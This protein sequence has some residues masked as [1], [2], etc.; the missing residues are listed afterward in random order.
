MIIPAQFRLVLLL[1]LA[2]L[3]RQANALDWAGHVTI[4]PQDGAIEATDDVWINV[5]SAPSGGATGARVVYSLDDGSNWSAAEMNANGQLGRHDWWHVNLG[6]FA[7]GTTIR[8]AVEVFAG[9]GGSLWDSNGGADY[10][11]TVNGGAGARWFGHARHDPPNQQVDPGETVTVSFETYPIGTAVSAR[12]VSSTDGFNWTSVNLAKTGT[13][14]ANDLWQG[15]IGSF[16]AATTNFYAI[17]VT[18]GP[19]DK[20]WDTNNGANYPVIVNSPYPGQWVGNT[21]HSPVNGAI[22]PGE[23]LSILAES[24]PQAK[25]LS[26]KAAYSVNGG[27]WQEANLPWHETSGSNDVW[28]GSLG[29]FAAGDRIQYATAVNFGY[30]GETWD[31]AGGTNYL[32]IV[33]SGTSTRWVGNTQTYPA[34]GEIDPED[35]LWINTESRL[36]SDSVS[37]RVVWRAN[38]GAWTSTPM[39]PNGTSGNKALWHVNLG[40]FPAGTAIEFAVEVLFADAETLWDNAGGTNH[41]AVVNAPLELLAVRN[42]DYWPAYGSIEAGEEVWINTETEPAGAATTVRVIYTTDDTT[43]LA[44]NLAANGEENGRTRWHASLGGFGSGTTV[45]FAIEAQDSYGTSV[46][47]NNWGEDFY[48]RVNSPIR[49]LYPDKARYNP[50]DPAVISAELFNPSGAALHGTLRLRISHLF[51][52]LAVLDS[53]VTVNAGQGLTVAV[54][55]T[56]RHDDFRGYAVAAEFIA[57]GTTLDRRSTAID[58]STDWTKFPR[59]GFFSDYYEGEQSWDSAAKAKELGKYHINAVQF[60]DWMWEHDRLVPYAC[61]GRV[62]NVFTQID[63]RVQ[64]LA[65]VSNKIAAAKGLNMFTLAYDLLYGDSGTGS[66]PLHPA[67]AAYNKPWSTEPID[68]RQHPLHDHTIWVMDCSHSDWQRWIYNQY[69]DAILKLGF[70]GIHLDNLGGAWS[71]R[72]NSND[73]IWEGAAF[74][75]FIAGCRAAVRNASP[76]GRV[77]H[78]DVYAG[79]LDQIAPSD[80]D[81]YYAEVWG[82]DRY[83]D[84]RDLVLRAKERGNKQVVLAAY[85]NL[86]DYTNYLSEA[87]V[88]L[89]DACVF[90][91]GA[92]HIEL[93]EGVEMLSNHYF[94]MHW[95]PMRPTLKRAMRDYYDFIVKYENLLFF[96]TLGGVSDG[97]AGA[98]LASASHALSKNGQSGAIWTTVRLWHDEFDTLNLINLNGVDELWR[99]RSGRPPAQTNIAL[100]YHADKK[101]QQVY[102]ATPDDGLGQPQAL[103][104]TEGSDS[105]GYFIEFTVPRLEYWDL[106]VL[107]KRTEIKIDGW[108]GDWTGAAPADIHATTIDRGEWVYKGDTNDYRTFSGAST[109][110]DLTEVRLTCDDT[111]VYFL[112]RMQ[113]IVDASRPAIGIA[114]NAHAGSSSFPWLGD[115]STPSGSIGLENASQ[116]AT[117]EIMVYSAGGTP[118]I[119]LFNG[120]IW[121]EPNAHDSAVAVSADNDCLEFRINRNDLDLFCPQIATISLATFRSS[122]NEAGNDATYDSPDGNNDGID[123]L[124]GEIGVA[125]NSWGRDLA[126]DRIGRSYSILFSPQGAEADLRVAWPIFDGQRIDIL[127]HEAYTVVARFTET[128]PAETSNFVFAVNGV[129][130]NPSGYFFQDETPG[131]FMN[132]IRFAWT[133]PD[134]GVCTVAVAYAASG[135]ALSAARIVNL[136]PDTDGDGIPDA[137]ED[138]NRNDLYEPLYFGE[139]CHTNTDTDGDGLPDGF[140]DGNRDGRITGDLNNNYRH[141]A[142]EQW[143]ETDPRQ[144]DTDGD[145]LPDGWEVAQNLNPWDDGIIGHTN[146]NTGAP[147]AAPD[148]GAAGDPDSDGA[149]NHEEWI[150]GTDPRSSVSVFTFSDIAFPAG[151]ETCVVAWRSISGRVYQIYTSTNLARAF[152]PVGLCIT[153][154]ENEVTT[155]YPPVGGPVHARFYQ[156]GVTAP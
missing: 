125:E 88:R 30:G 147:I 120:D 75:A 2:L 42:S 76:D 50:G 85:M 18:F 12:V 62:M 6:P 47:D 96:N 122:G 87:S 69:Q 129:V 34:Q 44:A 3:A 123:L 5:E 17:E 130:Q 118:R 32:A 127:S 58:V 138:V 97:T 95:P 14:G 80:V 64:S 142:G 81:V 61:D 135:Y 25:G 77:L 33:N 84:V 107:D 89:M 13:I 54:P 78:N 109:D 102:V 16:P 113:D 37:A 100:K 20:E 131:D 140:E 55:W 73:G 117:R 8:Y 60:Y 59:Y 143:G 19:A 46:W 72:H 148:H 35:D 48:F 133:S 66:A 104:F 98:D 82:Y 114:W 22:D 51:E 110:E 10:Y 23:I 63:Q 145:G 106:V 128:L 151:S 103:A 108:P 150:A 105:G 83:N 40:P 90:A 146:L 43:W 156:I 93:G 57:G 137:L 56:T 155:S 67:W 4:A 92:F 136:N 28:R 115:A 119:R 101:I 154:A 45:R 99:N 112:V 27:A 126:D 26:A 24:R 134:S 41:L 1:A 94:P 52:E 124:G 7:A 39:P 132:E 36:A 70:E 68:I 49:D 86:N 29:P 53:N 152:E 31:T 79:Y 9:G 21:R 141:D 153:A 38:A 65:T 111:Y 116:H 144:A 71:Y 121:Y 15:A 139:T 11:A 74:P 91:S 149:F